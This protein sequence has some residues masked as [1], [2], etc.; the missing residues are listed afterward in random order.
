MACVK[1]I[2]RAVRF[3][4]QEMKIAHNDLNP[5]NIL[6]RNTNGALYDPF[7]NYLALAEM[8]D[9][10]VL[11]CLFHDDSRH[12]KVA[13]F[14]LARRTDSEFSVSLIPPLCLLVKESGATD[15]GSI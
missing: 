7:F 9:M 10:V 12:F 11:F 6:F 15:G 4:H 13:D 1:D 5:N 3:L 2:G 8:A 14:G